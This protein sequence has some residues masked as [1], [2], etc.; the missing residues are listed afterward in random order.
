LY[1]YTQRFDVKSTIVS[2]IYFFYTV[3]NA[4][5]SEVTGI[6]EHKIKTNPLIYFFKGKVIK[7]QYA[8]I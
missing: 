3:S 7:L 8:N 5:T 4:I 2:Y 6:K 1:C